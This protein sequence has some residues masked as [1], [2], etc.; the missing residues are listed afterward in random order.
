VIAQRLLP[1]GSHT[2]AAVL[3]VLAV[4]A[5]PELVTPA[6]AAA[7]SDRPCMLLTLSVDDVDAVCGVLRERGVV[8]LNGPIDR[9]WGKRTAAFADPAGTAW[10]LAQ[11]IP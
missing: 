6:Q 9:P 8:L 1:E 11:D 5:A 7:I 10:E 3:N 2:G 4:T